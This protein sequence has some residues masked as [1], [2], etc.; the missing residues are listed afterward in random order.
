[1]SSN[2]QRRSLRLVAS[3]IAVVGVAVVS[4]PFVPAALT[5]VLTETVTDVVETEAEPGPSAGAERPVAVEVTRAV[6][7][8]VEQSRTVAGRVRPART[9]DLAFQIPGQIV[10]LSVEP[11]DEVRAGEVIAELDQIDFALAVDRAKASFDLASSELERAAGLA[12]RGVAADA[13]LDTARAQFAQAEVALREAQRRLSQTQI[14]SP[15]DATVARTF[16]DEYVNVTSA[17]PVARLQDLSEMRVVTSLPEELAAIAR[18]APEAFGA[19][20]TFPAVPGFAAQLALRSF[21]TESDATAQ[22]YDLEFAITGDIDPRLLPGMTADV[23]I[24]VAAEEK[25]PEAV[26]VPV[27]A[28]DTASRPEPSVWIYEESSGQ[29][30]RRTVR[31]GLPVD[32]E[33]VILEGLEGGELVVSGGWWRLSENQPVVVSGF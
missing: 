14:V 20:A 15:F 18:S 1:M 28:V 12:E 2:K 29:V 22:T 26:I 9:A 10:T 30:A 19:A 33:I 23:R 3:V 32:N 25:G 24:S 7:R 13:R 4:V 6:N 21:A 11:G 31:L 5:D 8:A 27:S 17:A 16:V